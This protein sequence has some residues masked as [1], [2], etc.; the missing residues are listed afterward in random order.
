MFASKHRAYCSC[1]MPAKQ[2]CGEALWCTVSEPS[3]T[4]GAL[5]VRACARMPYLDPAV[6]MMVSA[7]PRSHS[8]CSDTRMRAAASP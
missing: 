3:T 7:S 2:G 5:L 6:V 1:P 4:S 8:C